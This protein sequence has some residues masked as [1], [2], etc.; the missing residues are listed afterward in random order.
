M[1][2]KRGKLNKS[3]QRF[4]RILKG[5]SEGENGTEKKFEGKH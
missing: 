4:I 5:A 3:T 2:A 1:D